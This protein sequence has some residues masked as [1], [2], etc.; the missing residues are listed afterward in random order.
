MVSPKYDIQ[1][2]TEDVQRWFDE[3]GLTQVETKFGYDG[4]N[5]KGRRAAT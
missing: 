1:Q 3:A 5:A 2:G 4:I